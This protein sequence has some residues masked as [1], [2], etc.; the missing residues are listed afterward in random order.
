MQSVLLLRAITRT[1]RNKQRPGPWCD[2]SQKAVTDRRVWFKLVIEGSNMDLNVI[3]T[4]RFHLHQYVHDLKKAVLAKAHQNPLAHCERRMAAQSLPRGDAHSGARSRD[5][6]RTGIAN[7]KLSSLNVVVGNNDCNGLS[8][9]GSF[10]L[11]RKRCQM[12]TTTIEYMVH[13]PLLFYGDGSSTA[14]AAAAASVGGGGCCRTK[15]FRTP[16][17]WWCVMLLLYRTIFNVAST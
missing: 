6:G 1:N 3:S 8:L 11:V 13:G 16:S 7:N 4:Y 5:N 14:A 17:S 15:T 2:A 12:H 9:F 10:A